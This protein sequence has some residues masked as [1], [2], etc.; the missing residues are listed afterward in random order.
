MSK[1][2]LI[3]K[4]L[5]NRLTEAEKQQFAHWMASDEDFQREVAFH[6]NLQR[7]TRAHERQQLKQRLQELDQQTN[8]KQP[9]ARPQR[10]RWL[11]LA[12]LLL[13]MCLSVYWLCN[14]PSNPEK[15][16]AQYHSPF[17]NSLQPVSRD[18]SDGSLESRAFLFYENGRY[19]Q[20]LQQF[21]SIA[22][23]NPRPDFGFYQG[24]TLLQLERFEEASELFEA[25]KESDTQY[26][27]EVH[28]Y[29]ALA[30]IRLGQLDEG[31]SNLRSLQQIRP[32]YKKEAIERL[33]NEF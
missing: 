18:R 12:G 27:A 17:P 10:G 30:H 22:K 32:D 11:G 3:E 31:R 13:L 4:Y 23:D 1:D 14:Q 8:A 2:N 5:S 20:A 19:E 7:V 28:W 16:Y 6:E 25:L 24:L 9:P 15:I 29:G 33:L 21:E 26:R